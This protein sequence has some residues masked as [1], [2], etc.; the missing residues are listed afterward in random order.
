L[1]NHSFELTTDDVTRLEQFRLERLCRFF[2]QNLSHC[3]I[4]LSG[5]ETLVVQCSEPSILD[6]LLEDLEDLCYF[7][8]IIL[9]AKAIAVCFVPEKTHGADIC[10]IRVI[11]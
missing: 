11:L 5:R 10:H 3:F 7:A 6:N 4:Y 1:R 2:A 8:K 9:G